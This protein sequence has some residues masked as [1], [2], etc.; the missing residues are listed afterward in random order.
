MGERQRGRGIS[1][2]GVDGNKTL[3]GEL[4]ARDT[5]VEIQNLLCNVI[6]QY[7]LKVN[8]LQMKIIV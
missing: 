7:H 6:D 3:G 1:S 5:K 2:M 8:Y 4:G